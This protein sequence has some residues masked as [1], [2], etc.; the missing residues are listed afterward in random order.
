MAAPHV[1]GAVALLLSVEPDLVGQ[2]DQ[3]EEL[4]RGTALPLTTGQDCGDTSGSEIPNNA[5]GWGRI[6]VEA[7]ANMIWQAG[8]LRGRIVDAETRKPIAGVTIVVTRDGYTLSTQTDDSGRYGILLGAGRYGVSID[9]FGYSQPSSEL[10]SIKQDKNTGLNAELSQLP[11]GELRGQVLLPAPAPDSYAPVEGATVTLL[12]A[13]AGFQSTTNANGEYVI[14][15]VPL[16]DYDVQMT[17]PGFEDMVQSTTVTATTELDFIANPVIDYIVGD[18]GNSCS[19]PFEWIDATDGAA[20]NLGD[21]TWTSVAL[22]VPFTYYGNS[23][24]TLYISSNGFVSFGQ[25]YPKWSGVIP[26][27]G[28]PNNAI[29]GLGED[30]NPANGQQGV[31]YS[32]ALDDER[33]VIEYHQVEHWSS[34]NPETFEIILDARDNTIL[35]QYQQVSWPEFANVGLENSDGSR[36]VSYSYANDPP[37]TPGLS[38]KYTPFL[39]PA[40]ECE[41]TMT[42]WWLPLMLR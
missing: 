24:D 40:P 3:I 31:I 26:F 35:I 18:G 22:P 15:Q 27:V 34:G 2:V 29:Y 5:Y 37:L 25:G 7:A 36:G 9:A 33:F 23:Y 20:H 39:G 12:D 6:D 42:D 17:E 21:D 32:K 14:E 1:T 28:P 19:A 8:A 13:P 30:L 11:K 41:P 16:G 38:V 10:V 4:L